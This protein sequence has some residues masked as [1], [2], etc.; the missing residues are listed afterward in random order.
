MKRILIAVVASLFFSSNSFAQVSDLQNIA[1]EVSALVIKKGTPRVYAK[2]SDVEVTIHKIRI[3]NETV[4]YEAEAIKDPVGQ[5][6]KIDYYLTNRDFAGENITDV[7]ADELIWGRPLIHHEINIYDKGI[8]GIPEIF[9]MFSKSSGSVWE[10]FTR[11]E[12]NLGKKAGVQ[13]Y[14]YVQGRIFHQRRFWRDGWVKASEVDKE[15]QQYFY[16]KLLTEL[17]V[18]LLK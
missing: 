15:E 8:T 6:L 9:Q 11:E 14:L 3:Y 10:G 4:I 12:R 2:G 13:E 1:H 17:K 16:Q 5:H 18:L 7:V